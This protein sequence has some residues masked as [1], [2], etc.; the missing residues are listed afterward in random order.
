MKLTDAQKTKAVA[1]FRAA[2]VAH[3]KVW[4]VMNEIEEDTGVEFDGVDE[5]IEALAGECPSDDEIVARVEGLAQ[6]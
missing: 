5:L 6:E 2:A 3:A 4:R 1:A